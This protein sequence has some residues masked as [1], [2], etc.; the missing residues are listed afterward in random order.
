MMMRKKSKLLIYTPK[1]MLDNKEENQNIPRTHTDAKKNKLAVTNKK[2][3]KSKL[4]I[5]PKK[6]TPK[7][8]ILHFLLTSF[9]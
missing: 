3:N 9:L 7:K 5:N 2:K 6:L 1:K 4:L 8:A